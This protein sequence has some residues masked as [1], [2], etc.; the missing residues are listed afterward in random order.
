MASQA[1]VSHTGHELFGHGPSTMG[2]ANGVA[3]PAPD[4]N[5]GLLAGVRILIVDDC[6]LFRDNLAEVM[7]GNGATV[8]VSWDLPTLITSMR[9][10]RLN[11]LLLNLATRDSAT[12]L[13]AAMKTNSHARVIVL[14]VSEQDESGIVACAEAGVAGYHTRSQSFED[15]LL[16]MGKVAAGE[17]HCS[18]RVSA[19][20]LRRLST[21]AS[22]RVPASR[23]LVLTS[24]EAQILEMIRLGMSN[25]EIATQLC[26]AL[27]TVKNHVHSVLGKLGVSTRAQ[28]AAMSNTLQHAESSARELGP[29][30]SEM[31]PTVH[32]RPRG[33]G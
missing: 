20:L 10:T 2:A 24:R 16:L 26:I 28:A 32:L 3:V 33:A 13:E 23:E 12:L 27:H 5:L 17:S 1:Y 4:V 30:W 31:G 11:L 21:L 14:G 25:R 6:T 7:V 15:L 8:S 22:Q 18:P 9:E 29:G 19:V